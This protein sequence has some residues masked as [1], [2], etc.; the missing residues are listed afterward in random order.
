MVKFF[1]LLF[2][3]LSFA[4]AMNIEM[5]DAV[6][7]VELHDRSGRVQFGKGMFVSGIGEFAV[8]KSIMDPALKD[9][10]DYL[11]SF[12][13]SDDRPL[14]DIQFSFCEKEGE[15]PYCFYKANYIPYRRISFADKEAT[16]ENEKKLYYFATASSLEE[17]K[18]D[19][20]NSV[21]WSVPKSAAGRIPG[22]I[23]VD[24]QNGKAKGVVTSTRK[25]GNYQVIPIYKNVEGLGS[26]P[27]APVEQQSNNTLP[28]NLHE[29]EKNMLRM[30]ADINKMSEEQIKKAIEE[31]FVPGG[32]GARSQLKKR[33]DNNKFSKNAKEEVALQASARGEQARRDFFKVEQ[34][35][36]EAKN[37][38]DD[39]TEEL[40]K[41]E[42]RLEGKKALQDAVELKMEGQKENLIAT[43]VKLEV[44][45]DSL[46]GE[47]KANLEKELAGLKEGLEKSQGKAGKLANEIGELKAKIEALKKGLSQTQQLSQELEQKAGEAAKAN[48]GAIQGA[49]NYRGD[50]L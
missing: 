48:A 46:P 9:P 12:R 27:Y 34:E 10:Y 2:F 3:N 28:K 7:Y 36:K 8:L 6:V 49:K 44:S 40:G 50:L 37:K 23:L 32:V 5:K 35:A 38:L 41:L 11:L 15:H 42:K 19:Q 20:K 33:Q 31:L 47:E 16:P 21:F 30:V 45:G 26:K 13:T 24:L 22:T 4:M 1:F 14:I 18:V 43:S 29:N 39:Q 17:T 25:G